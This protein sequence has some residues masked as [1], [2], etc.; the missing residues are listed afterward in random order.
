MLSLIFW[1]DA[2]ALCPS[3]ADL[4]FCIKT[5]TACAC[6]SAVTNHSES[7]LFY[8]LD[9]VCVPAVFSTLL[10]LTLLFTITNT[11]ALIRMDSSSLQT[12]WPPWRHDSMT[13]A[14]ISDWNSNTC[15]TWDFW[16]YSQLSPYSPSSLFSHP[17]PF[18][19]TIVQRFVTAAALCNLS[20]GQ[21]NTFCG[22]W[23]EG[24]EVKPMGG[25]EGG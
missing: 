9:G 15:V 25:M 16:P 21:Q 12:A 3:C 24:V 4:W 8:V 10:L 13:P 5:M 23:R 18:A 1:W 14:A 7:F 17:L 6:S 19:L 2:A 11:L 22:S 20:H